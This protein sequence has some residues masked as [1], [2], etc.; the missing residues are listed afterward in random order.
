MAK[1]SID[2]GTTNTLAAYLD[3]NGEPQYLK[4]DG[5][6]LIPSCIYIEE[7]AANLI[8]GSVALDMWAD[9]YYDVK[10]LFR[11]WKPLIG[12]GKVLATLS[13]GKP[14][15]QVEITPE[16]L[17]TRMVEY[18][19]RE[20][21]EGLGGME[22][23]EVLVTVPHGWRR[24]TPEKCR[25]AREAVA[26][27]RIG[28]RNITVHPVTVSEPVAA[29]AYW[30][31]TARKQ[32]KTEQLSQKTL[33]VCDIGGGTFDLSLIRVGGEAKPLDVIDATNN[34]CAGDYV[35]ALLCAWG[36]QQ[37]NEHY[38]TR[39]P[40][41]A[42]EILERL[43]QP[44]EGWLREWFLHMR[45]AKE[46]LSTRA[47]STRNMHRTIPVKV[48]LSDGNH[49]GEFLLSLEDFERC[50][51]PFYAAAQDLIRNFLR[52]NQDRL[53]YAILPAGGGSRIW[54][55]QKHI[56][57][58][59]LQ[60]FYSREEADQVLNRLKINWQRA[61]VAIVFGAALIANGVESVQERILNPIGLI[62][63]VKSSV[64][65]MLGLPERDQDVLLIP[66]LDKG[67]LLPARVTSMDLGLKT[68]IEGGES[69][70]LQVVVDD[71]PQ[72]PWVQR[73][74]IS[75][76]GGGKAQSIEWEMSVDG[77]GV[78]ALRLLPRKGQ[79]ARVELRI[80][81]TG[82]GRAKILFAESLN[83]GNIPRVTPQA[84]CRALD[85][86]GAS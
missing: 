67:T 52:K 56:L 4:I 10:R 68:S 82:S 33:L 45:K 37:F 83:I 12:E 77:D 2:L 20:I 17:T 65:R 1:I 51:Q 5:E 42:E 85:S 23:E 38:H 11:A 40:T 26:Q 49:S 9:Q 73:Q 28:N 60:E 3:A 13:I 75:H 29:A 61:D 64:A 58:P 32:H 19:L 84:L 16:Y 78:L 25:A 27:A 35:D 48:T 81:R 15:R 30:V 76:P 59:V 54:G 69:V 79:E 62:V 22:V 50:L 47:L 14:P 80:E 63:K 6:I 57:E 8:V 53:P 46:T 72:D 44:Q 74:T 36:C 70:D 24:V 18:V 86:A 21:S 43:D 71:D 39:Y 7:P 34:Y 55:I 66:I 31:W 41:T